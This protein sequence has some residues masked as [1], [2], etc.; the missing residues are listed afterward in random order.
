V[1]CPQE[2]KYRS[3]NIKMFFINVVNLKQC[4]RIV[5]ALKSLETINKDMPWIL[6]VQKISGINIY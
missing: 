2:A 6:N 1:G 3:V 5:F 4:I